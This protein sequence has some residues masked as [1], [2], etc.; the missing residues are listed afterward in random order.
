MSDLL[1]VIVLSAH[2]ETLLGV[3]RPMCLRGYVAEE[4]VLELVHSGIGEHKCRVVLYDH[5]C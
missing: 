2:T 1:Q 3:S 5:R 4:D